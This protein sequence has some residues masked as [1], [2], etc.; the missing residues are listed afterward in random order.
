MTGADA[1]HTITN[2]GLVSHELH[3]PTIC[4]DPGFVIT[5]NPGF[6][7]EVAGGTSVSYT[8]DTSPRNCTVK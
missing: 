3:N 8:V 4:V 1:S 6:T 5:Q 2:A 7:A